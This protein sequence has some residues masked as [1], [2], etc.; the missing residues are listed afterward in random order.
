MH[1]ATTESKGG[2]AMPDPNHPLRPS[3][4]FP[5]PPTAVQ[6]R[7]GHGAWLRWRDRMGRALGNTLRR[8]RVPGAI[9][10]VD[11]DDPVS[12]QRI[13]VSVGVLFT[14]LSVNG[15]DYYFRRVSGEF[16]GTG[17]GPA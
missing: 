15:R 7:K 9:R 10:D 3:F 5:N 1:G 16:A 14:R 4:P 12:G 13:Q 6:G 11:I 8:L 17:S 2:T